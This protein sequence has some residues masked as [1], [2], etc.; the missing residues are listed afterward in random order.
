[1]ST[2]TAYPDA[3]TG[4][5]TVD[6]FVTSGYQSTIGAAHAVT[7]GDGASAVSPYTPKCVLV[8]ALHNGSG[9]Y[10]GRAFFLFDTAAIDDVATISAAV[11]SLF[12]D[13]FAYVNNTSSTVEIVATNPASSNNLVAGD[14]GN[15]SF[16]SFASVSHGSLSQSAYNDFTL[17]ASGIANIS[18]TGISKFGAV[19]GL[20]LNQTNFGS[21]QDNIMAFL[22]ADYTGTA[23][24][25]KLVVTYSTSTDVTVSATV[26]SATFTI[27]AYTVTAIRNVTISPTAQ[28]ATFSV[29]SAT[30]IIDEYYS[31]PQPFTA[32]FSIPTYT[33]TIADV[34]I[35]PSVQVCTFTIP[36]YTPDVTA[37]PT[38]S[39]SVQVCTFTI[40]S[41]TVD[42]VSNITIS[43]SVL[44]ATFSILTYTAL[45]DYWEE[46]FA[47]PA[48]SWSDKIAQ[49]STTW[50]NK[51]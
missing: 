25:P 4:A 14:F 46:K 30:E 44:T 20:D 27:P 28:T 6:G 41:Y 8:R 1:M 43:P 39:P 38:I 37:N 7:T 49:P 35:Q 3:G 12:G 11:L 48:T 19:S 22:E 45:G 34:I 18:K 26:L 15:V 31:P 9:F 51:Y 2:L 13:S 24:D 47:Q 23:N 32:T 42:V 21:V 33:V 36:T 10:L 16:T 29:Q 17:N 5:T 50:N 40:P